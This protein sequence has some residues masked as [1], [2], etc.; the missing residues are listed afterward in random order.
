MIVIG[1]LLEEA[2]SAF[3]SNKSKTGI[4]KNDAMDC[5]GVCFGDAYVNECMYCIE[6]TTGFKDINGLKGEFAGAY[7]QDCNQDCSGKAIIDDCDI[8]SGG[9]TEHLFNNDIDCTNTCFGSA[10]IDECEICS[11]GNT[12]ILPNQD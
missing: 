12:K 9:T 6:G 7:G 4:K 3:T 5:A 10:F 1:W 8:C 2:N 11:G